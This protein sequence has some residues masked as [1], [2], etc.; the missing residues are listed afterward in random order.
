MSA[1]F[2]RA[3]RT[4]TASW[5]HRLGPAWAVVMGVAGLA[6]IP[7][8]GTYAVSSGT[9]RESVVSLVAADLDGS[10]LIPI[11]FIILSALGFGYMAWSVR[12]AGARVSC[13]RAGSQTLAHGVALALAA[14]PLLLIFGSL[15]LVE[16]AARQDGLWPLSHA[17]S[18]FGLPWPESGWAAGLSIPRWGVFMNPLA[19]LL[20]FVA[21]LGAT[22]LPPFDT[23][24]AEAEA[25]TSLHAEGSTQ[26]MGN[27]VVADGVNALLLSGFVVTLGFGGWAIPWVDEARLAAVT[28]ELYGATLGT[29]LCA[30]LHVA[31]FGVKVLL[32][33]GVQRRMMRTWTPLA[34]DRMTF[35]CHRVLIPLAVAN[36][37][38]TGFWLV[39]RP[40]L[41]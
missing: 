23:V 9:A 18:V 41:A 38:A 4:P 17:P 12:D 11:A 13:L 2:T 28:G 26:R 7:F 16:I 30:V 6:V 29:L 35:L 10:A 27:A 39:A 5:L 36:A 21:G 24:A 32:V 3:G 8:G 40:G 31:S 1:A 15:D 14:M 22:R 37:F 20:V 33:M 25:L 34:E 19:V